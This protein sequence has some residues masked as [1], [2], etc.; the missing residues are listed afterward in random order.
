MRALFP[1]LAVGL[2]AGCPLVRPTA[3]V[4]APAAICF[5]PDDPVVDAKVGDTGVRWACDPNTAVCWDDLG[6]KVAPALAAKALSEA[7]GRL[8]CVDF[9]RDLD[10]RGVIRADDKD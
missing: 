7:R 2:L 5:Q 4:A 3:P 6:E 9:I 10:K 8:A 1:L